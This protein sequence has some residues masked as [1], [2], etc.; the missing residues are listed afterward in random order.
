MKQIINAREVLIMKKDRGYP[1]VTIYERA[2]RRQERFHPW[3]Y[4]NEIKSIQGEYTNGELVDVISESN[5]YIGT[6]FINDNSKIRIRIISRNT[7]DCF[8]YDFWKR[9]I[10]YAIDY[11]KTVMSSEEDLLACRIIFGEADEIPGLTVDRFNNILVAQVL[12]LGIEIRKEEIFRAL[13][14]VFGEQGEK[15]DGIYERNDVTIR[16]KEGLS[17]YKGY[18]ELDNLVK[19]DYTTVT[20]AENGIKYLV[21][22]ENG[23]KTGFFLDQKYNRKMTSIVARGKRVLDCCTHTGSF[24][25]NCAMGGAMHVDALDVSELAL[26]KAKENAILNN[27][28]D[29]IS[30]VVGNIFD[31]LPTVRRGEYDFIILDPPAFTKSSETKKYA[32]AGYR[33]INYRAMKA[34]PRGGFLAT[35]S[36]SHFMDEDSFI[37]MINEAAN[38]AEVRVRLF[39]KSTQAPDHPMLMNVPETYYLKFFIFQVF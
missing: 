3:V 25:L 5:S 18:Y 30:F 35:C 37:E 10:K 28:E 26:E 39:Y 27:L 16:E 21:D 32:F 14:E 1:L 23:Q 17:Q 38:K 33:E 19:P 8:D 15:I 13:V 29:R 9:R 22:I 11:R 24:A 6:G 31:Y 4:D 2:R 7:N 36:C 12:S 34:L 20:I